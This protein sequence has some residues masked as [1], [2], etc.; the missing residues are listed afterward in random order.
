MNKERLKEFAFR[1]APFLFSKTRVFRNWKIAR[2]WGQ[3][4][5][6]EK[7]KTLCREPGVS[8]DQ[9]Q[10]KTTEKL[11]IILHVFHLEIFRE[12]LDYLSNYD[13]GHFK[14][15]ITAPAILTEKISEEMNACSVPFLIRP[16]E[17]RGR[18]MLPFLIILQD[19]L[20]EQFSIILKIHTK[21]NDRRLAGKD[22]RKDLFNKLLT[23]GSMDQAMTIFKTQEQVGMIVPAGHLIPVSLYYGSSAARIDLYC[24]KLGLNAAQISDLNFPAGSM[25]YI[26]A[27]ALSPLLKLGISEK[28]FEPEAGQVDGTMAHALERAIAA[29]TFSAGYLTVDSAWTPQKNEISVNLDHQFTH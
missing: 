5:L 2:A 28:D 1:T 21:K 27:E 23:N 11:A 24:R 16:V 14:V 13:S 20:N 25:F 29:S 9:K 17:N 18:D 7:V 4:K 15:F 22:W 3:P 10:E 19:V 26:R 12:V 8:P 6:Q